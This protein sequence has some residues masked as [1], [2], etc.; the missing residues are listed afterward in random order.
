MIIETAILPVVVVVGDE[1][2]VHA[3]IAKQL[4]F[5]PAELGFDLIARD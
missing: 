5:A 3:G 2:R 4:G 1:V